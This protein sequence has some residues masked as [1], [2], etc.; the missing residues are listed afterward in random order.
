MTTRLLAAPVVVLVATVLAGCGAKSNQPT[1][2]ERDLGPASTTIL[3]GAADGKYLHVFSASISTVA[4]GSPRFSATFLYVGT[5]SDRL[6]HVT[7][8]LGTAALTQPLGADAAVPV[9]VA[10]RVAHGAIAAA[11]TGSTVRVSVRLADH[12]SVALSVPIVGPASTP[13]ATATSAS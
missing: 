4:A 10:L 9:N 6:V 8:P 12:G 7:T 13:T 11:T 3:G 2:Q 5:G 1:A